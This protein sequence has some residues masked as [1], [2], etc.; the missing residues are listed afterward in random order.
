MGIKILAIERQKNKAIDSLCQDYLDRIKHNIPV[1]LQLLPSSKIDDPEK[2]KVNETAQLVK[3]LKESDTVVICDENGT[4]YNS[5][6][7]SK[8][9]EK[10]LAHLRG[11]LVFIIG[12]SYGL[13]H[14][15]LS[16]Y[17]SS[18][19]LSEFVLPHHI[20]RLVL[21]EQVYRAL[22]ILKNT[23]YHH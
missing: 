21:I 9:I 5:Q 11:D 18:I 15:Q 19:K 4:V 3:H 22:S 10:Q 8:F 17:K 2:Q 20:A 23:G 7:F 12:G 16:P 1:T 13:D 14:A 6:G